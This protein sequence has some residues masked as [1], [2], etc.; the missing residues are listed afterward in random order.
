[1]TLAAVLGVLS[2]GLFPGV[3]TADTL[4]LFPEAS[5]PVEEAICHPLAADFEY[6]E[7][8]LGLRGSTSL[9]FF[10]AYTDPP[11]R[12]GWAPVEL[13]WHQPQLTN[14]LSE[15]LCDPSSAHR[16]RAALALGLTGSYISS[17]ELT[18]ALEDPDPVVA[19]YAALALTYMG[20]AP[21][22]ARTRQVL[23]QGEYWEQ[24]YA[25]IGL[26]RTDVA[27]QRDFLLGCAQ[28]A[29]PRVRELIEAALET[30]P[31]IPPFHL[32][33]TRQV[34]GNPEDLW[35]E[36]AYSMNLVADAWWHYG[37]YP[38]ACYSSEVSLVFAPYEVERYEDIAWLLWS[39]GVEAEGQSDL[40]RAAELFAQAEE[41]LM[42]AVVLYPEDWRS[43]AFLGDYYRRQHRDHDSLEPLARAREL[44]P[45]DWTR[46]HAYAHALEAVG[47]GQEALAL[48][49]ETME[50]FPGDPAAPLACER[51]RRELA[52]GS[53]TAPGADESALEQ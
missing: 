34:S 21:G 52:G 27:G 37:S 3:A 49:Q 31:W 42:R 43:H 6:L 16:A 13:L 40:Q 22:V 14:W 25:V 17:E 5:S 44:A 24:Y 19:D 46:W 39:M 10:R 29:D 36:F 35:A 18:A 2:L 45:D 12:P 11:A 7:M 26:W 8:R 51:L 33:S 38:F 23:Q 53:D 4:P 41:T 30:E 20:L 32:F 47:R 28:E 15:L 1:V 48:W 50:R 9:D